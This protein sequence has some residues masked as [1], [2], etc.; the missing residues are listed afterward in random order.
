VAVSEIAPPVFAD[1]VAAVVMVGE[2]LV[3]V[4]VSPGSL[5]AVEVALLAASPP[6]EATQLYVPGN[7]ELN[8]SDGKVPSPPTALIEVNRGVPAH[9][10][11]LGPKTVKVMVPVGTLPPARIAVSEIGPPAIAE[12]VAW[13]V[14]VG[15]ALVTVELSPGSLQAVVAVL[16]KASPP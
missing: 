12:T 13:V 7:V 2:E 1:G 10:A 11:L 9:V 6:Y 4:E 14:I 3:T 15:L 16:L 5:Q 8:E